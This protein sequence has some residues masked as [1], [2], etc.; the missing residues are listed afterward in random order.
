MPANPVQYF[1]EVRTL[2]G[3]NQLVT[4]DPDN[5]PTLMPDLSGATV[6]RVTDYQ[7]GINQQGDAPDYVTGRQD[8]TAWKKGPIESQG[9]LTFPFVLGDTGGGIGVSLFKAGANLVKYPSEN[10]TITSSV[11][12]TLRGCKVNTASIECQAGGEITSRAQVWGIVTDEDLITINSFGDTERKLFPDA[13]P[14]GDSDDGGFADGATVTG[15]AALN[16]EQIP[17][18][19]VVKITGAPEGM[20]VVGFSVNIDNRLVRN[21]TMGNND[22]EMYS[23]F[24][25]NAQSITANQRM[26]TGSV[27]WQSNKEGGIQQVAAVGLNGLTIEIGRPTTVLKLTM[28]NCLWNATPPSLAPGDRVTVESSY[29]A[30]GA[31]EQ[32]FDALIIE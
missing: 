3:W 29:I 4:I 14:A 22:D 13:S 30:M 16:L 31:N 11:H 20:F 9:D 23:P 12:P 15:N 18:W 28:A 1:S 2:M 10:F 26:I 8:R 7:I 17:M 6:L 21:F 32:E 24:G 5:A 19:D 25:L 27:T